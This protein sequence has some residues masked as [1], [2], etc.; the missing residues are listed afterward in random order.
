M[1]S[2]QKRGDKW[3]AL[4]RIRGTTCSRT[5]ATKR[6]A[7]AWAIPAEAELRQQAEQGEQ[8]EARTLGTLFLRYRDEITVGKRGAY[9]ETI[10]LNCLLA[11][12]LAA[13]PL[14]RLSASHIAA[15]RDRR[16]QRVKPGT[17]IRE[18]SIISAVCHV[19]ASEWKWL[20][21][22]PCRDVKRPP[23]PEAR[24]RRIHTREIEELLEAFHY[25]REEKARSVSERVAVAFL[26]AIETAMRR[27]E[28][29]NLRWED[30]DFQSSIARIPKGKTRAARREVPLT[31]EAKR[32][33][34]QLPRDS[35]RIF[36]LNVWSFNSAFRAARSKTGIQNL[37]FHDTRHEAIT[38][39]AQKIDVLPL[40]RIIG[41]HNLHQL[42]VYYNEAASDIAKRL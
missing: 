6:E 29:L 21:M 2:Y 27:G 20:E 1:A 3:R 37:H 39:L 8:A 19:A 25:R 24:D 13:V 23:R 33:L 26:F 35:T 5:F 42:L 9:P 28:I 30:I 34:H 31:R 17:V 15:W 40:A 11:D 4:V 41:H 38:R 18:L 7:R 32:L 14:A 16:L 36:D 12:T 10:R 22:N